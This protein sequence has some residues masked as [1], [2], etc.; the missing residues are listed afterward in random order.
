MTEGKFAAL[1]VKIWRL[2]IRRA[3]HRGLGH[4]HA[5]KIVQGRITKLCA[6]LAK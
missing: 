2:R 1:V 6:E 4:T 3:I 5:A